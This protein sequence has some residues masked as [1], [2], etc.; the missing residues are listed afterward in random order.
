MFYVDY[1]GASQDGPSGRI[2]SKGP[3]NPAAILNVPQVGYGFFDNFTSF[4]DVAPGAA[5]ATVGNAGRYAYVIDTAATAGTIKGISIRGGGVRL[6]TPATDNH[7]VLLVASTG[8][9]FV[10]SDSDPVKPLIFEVSVKTNSIA[11]TIAGCFMGLADAASLDAVNDLMADDG[12]LTAAAKFIGFH[13]L[14]G[15]GDKIDFVYKNGTGNAQVTL[16]ADMATLVADT[17]I[18]LGFVYNPQAVPAKRITIYVNNTEQTTYVTGTQIATATFPD[19]V[20]LNPVMGIHNAAA[21]AANLDA[22]WW[23]C[24]QDQ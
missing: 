16:I 5:G 9:G 7:Q 24:M 3:V 22:Q 23:Y 12:T 21:A 20:V 14:E 1:A 15:D 8:A 2:W 19:N 13:R 10:L 11:D 6:A 4:P 17:I 18:K